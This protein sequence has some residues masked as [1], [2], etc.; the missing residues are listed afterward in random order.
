MPPVA[1][2][3]RAA[4]EAWCRAMGVIRTECWFWQVQL[5]KPPGLL[6]MQG[7]AKT[8]R[9]AALRI[10]R[11]LWTASPKAGYRLLTWTV[12]RTRPQLSM[13]RRSA[14]RWLSWLSSLRLPRPLPP[15]RV[16]R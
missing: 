1:T 15:R 10:A 3:D 8:R 7:L 6:R 13:S 5:W 9:A 2:F 14:R 4:W 11:I 12:S 16:E